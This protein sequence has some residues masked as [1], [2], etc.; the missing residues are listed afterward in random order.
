MNNNF[1]AFLKIQFL[2]TVTKTVNI[3]KIKSLI[4][5]CFSAMLYLTI[6]SCLSCGQLQILAINEILESD[7]I[8]Q[9]DLLEGD[10]VLTGYNAFLPIEEKEK[11]P[12]FSKLEVIYSMNPR[13][14][15]L[16]VQRE[17]DKMEHDFSLPSG[18]YMIYADRN[19]IKIKRKLF[20]Y[21]I[22]ENLLTLDSNYDPDLGPDD[23]IYVFKK[24]NT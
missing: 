3:I 8:D 6:L 17:D 11:T 7:H 2:S 10:W 13:K 21:H 15:E 20:K 16:I 5:F 24:I 18:E 22:E 1:I 9:Y 4:R 19:L 12:D 14:H 23:I